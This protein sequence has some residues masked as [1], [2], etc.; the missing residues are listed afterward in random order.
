MTVSEVKGFGSQ[1][2]HREVYA[3][4]S[5]AEEKQLEQRTTQATRHPGWHAAFQSSSISR[6]PSCTPAATPSALL[7]LGLRSHIDIP[8]LSTIFKHPDDLKKGGNEDSREEPVR[9]ARG[10]FARS[11]RQE[12]EGGGRRALHRAASPAN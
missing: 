8:A 12:D 1:K 10:L 11:S 7:A 2:G 9:Q 3:Y 5:A 4:F 6:E